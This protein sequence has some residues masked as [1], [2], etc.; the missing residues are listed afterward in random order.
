MS[1]A[2]ISPVQN[3]HVPLTVELHTALKAEAA[4]SPLRT[5]CP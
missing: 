2:S 5:T 1:S 4:L 3:L